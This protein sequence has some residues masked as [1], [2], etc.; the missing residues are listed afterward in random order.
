MGLLGT[1]S[2]QTY[3]EGDNLGNYR[4]TSLANIV[5]GFMIGYVGDGKLIDNVRKSD[6]IFHAKRGLQEFSYDILKTVKAI[7]VELGSSLSLAMPQDY[8]SYVKLTYS[9]DDGV[10]RIIYPTTL[11]VNPTQ[12][13]AQDGDYEYIYDDNG[14]VIESSNSYIEDKWKEFDTDN[15]TGNLSSTDDYYI[16]TDEYLSYVGGRRYGLEPEHQQV[17]GYFTINERTGSFNFSS[18]LSGKIIILEYVSDSLGTDSEMKIHKFA[19]EALYKHIAFNIVAAKRNVPEYV[20]QR[21][22]KERR[23]AMRN[24]KLRLSKLNLEEMAQIMRGKSKRIKN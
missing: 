18:D 13:P 16:G 12:M 8:V 5:N 21:F 24:A 9:G 4:Y 15:I 7:E 11:T 3:Y 10:K 20:V 6:V 17:N 1:T 2:E 14:D 23:A 19:E 22:K